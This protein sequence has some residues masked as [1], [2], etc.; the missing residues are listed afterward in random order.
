M[1]IKILANKNAIA[2]R[3]VEYTAERHRRSRLSFEKLMLQIEHEI[4]RNGGLYPFNNGILNGIELLKRAGK[5]PAYLQK[6]TEKIRALKTEVNAWLKRVSS[7]IP[8]NTTSIRREVNRREKEIVA[9]LSASR[10]AYA[11]LELEFAQITADLAEANQKIS[12][13][14]K[15]IATLAVRLAGETITQLRPKT[16]RA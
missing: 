8:V 9:A 16:K 6:K 5:S 15:D 2:S 14:Q 13:L 3:G 4:D 10:Q 7:D 12:T 1:S 11:E